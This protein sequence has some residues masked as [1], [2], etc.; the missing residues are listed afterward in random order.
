MRD[1]GVVVHAVR[2]LM[3]DPPP[4][5]QLLE[6]GTDVFGAISWLE[7]AGWVLAIDAMDAAGA[8]GTLYSCSASQVAPPLLP[9][10]LH[11]LGLLAVLEF[12]PEHLRPEI[13]ILGVQPAVVDYGLELSPQVELALPQIVEAAREIAAARRPR[14][15]NAA[16]PRPRG[17]SCLANE[18]TNKQIAPGA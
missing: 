17:R 3:A 14:P 6:V 16:V 11:E 15:D 8:P 18:A 5:T 1:D 9:K 12:I 2:Q 4:G 13:T 7:G 10:S